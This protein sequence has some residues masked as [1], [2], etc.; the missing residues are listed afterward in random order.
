MLD[1]NNPGPSRIV[2]H[3]ESKDQGLHTPET[4]TPDA[5][6][7]GT[8]HGDDH[9]SGGVRSSSSSLY[10]SF[11]SEENIND[12]KE[13]EGEPT[14]AIRGMCQ[15]HRVTPFLLTSTS[16]RGRPEG[17]GTWCCPHSCQ[18]RRGSRK[19]IQAS[20]SV[21]RSYLCRLCKTPSSPSTHLLKIVDE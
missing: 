20:Q 19:Q 8:D 2:S 4:S 3:N 17:H 1:E 16:S 12:T 18:C 7:D 10:F 13:E 14:E 11:L 15:C 21:A 9:T 5:V 6:A